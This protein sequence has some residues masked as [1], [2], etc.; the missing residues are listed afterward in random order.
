[1]K[2]I[3]KDLLPAIDEVA[4][5]EAVEKALA[6]VL[7]YRDFDFE[8]KEVKMISAYGDAVSES[9]RSNVTSDS[10]ANVALANVSEEE[11]RKKH[12][13][14][15][16]RALHKLSPRQRTLITERYLTTFDIY[17]KDVYYG[18]MGISSKTYEKIRAEAFYLLA[19][20]LRIYVERG[21]KNANPR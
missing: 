2:S 7:L 11:R 20:H 8:R 9:Q 17:D 3:V 4:T 16:E 6:E 15:V 5:R 18:I 14:S 21:D 10:T 19:F 1:M 13:F 12:I